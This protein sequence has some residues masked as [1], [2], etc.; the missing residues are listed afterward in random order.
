M[1]KRFF[2][3]ALAL[4]LLTA[5]ASPAGAPAA[6]GYTFTDD[7][8]RP[9]T[10]AAPERVA[11][12]GASFADV[13]Q[14]AGGQVAI[15]TSDALEETH[16]GLDGAVNAGSLKSPDLEVILAGGADFVLLNGAISGQLE[17]ADA[18]ENAGVACA[19]FD[20]EH[21][22]DYLR[23][24]RICTAITGREDLYIQN[25]EAVKARV[26]AAIAAAE[27][28]EGPSVLLIRA[29]STG[30]KAKNSENNMTGRMLRD[31][32][33]R[34]I[35]DSE[36]GLLEDLSMEKILLEDPDFIFVTTM[37][38]TDEALAALAAA[39]QSDPAWADLRAVRE[40]RYVVLRT[41]LF[42]QK[43]NARWGES[44]E[45]LSEILYGAAA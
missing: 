20:V 40:G 23:M 34:N 42:H 13:W 6:K 28:R 16:L 41:E 26:D 30:A 33:C 24:L 14:L 4:C 29:Y 2:C 25:G 44:Y 37:G 11:A 15:T 3:L 17:L 45:I 38:G 39:L 8:G 18:L 19:V 10:V 9:V 1:K 31:L 12:M 21:F 36:T 35:A 22:E 5:C 7:L 43:P 27:G 32:G